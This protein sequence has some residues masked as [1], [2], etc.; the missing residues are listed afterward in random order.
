MIG[1]SAL[2]HI[3]STF[4]AIDGGSGLDIHLVTSIADIV[5]GHVF[6]A[7]MLSSSRRRRCRP[8]GPI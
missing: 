5:M 6:G 3:E 4:A 8:P 2:R 1:P 7:A